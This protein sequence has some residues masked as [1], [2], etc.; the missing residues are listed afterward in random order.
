MWTLRDPCIAGS[1][2]E[3]SGVRS[4]TFN[5]LMRLIFPVL[6]GGRRRAPHSAFG[7]KMK[8][9]PQP[10]VCFRN[11]VGAGGQGH[12][13]LLTTPCRGAGVVDDH[14]HELQLGDRG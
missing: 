6:A 12:D 1:D 8:W 11:I 9:G 2:S 10:A 3:S 4:S 14:V 5:S 7:S 13:V